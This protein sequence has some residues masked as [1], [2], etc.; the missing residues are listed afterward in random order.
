MIKLLRQHLKIFCCVILLIIGA[1]GLVEATRIRVGLLNVNGPFNPYRVSLIAEGQIIR[2][3]L[4]PLIEF[5]DS[6]LEPIL[7]TDLPSISADGLAYSFELKQGI[8]FHNQQELTTADVQLTIE[9]F[10]LDTTIINKD[11]WSRLKGADAFIEGVALSIA[12]IKII[13]DYRFKLT[14]AQPFPNFIQTLT[15]LN[16]VILPGGKLDNPLIGSGPFVLGSSSFTDSITL[17]RNENYHQQN[18]LISGLEFRFYTDSFAKIDAFDAGEIDVCPLSRTSYLEYAQGRIASEYIK[19]VHLNNIF[20]LMIGGEILK[21]SLLRQA[22]SLAINRTEIAQAMGKGVTP[23]HNF[24]PFGVDGAD[25]SG[26]INYS[27]EQAQEIL[28]QKGY[29]NGLE[30]TF[31]Q[32]QSFGYEDILTKMLQKSNIYLEFLQGPVEYF[33]QARAKGE[34]DLWGVGI[35]S[36]SA[37]AYHYF[38]PLILMSDW[39]YELNNALQKM[40][41]E[42][43]GEVNRNQRIALY[44]Q[45]HQLVI[46]EALVIPLIHQELLYLMNHQITDINY[47]G[48]YLDFKAASWY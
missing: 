25:I 9:N 7:L 5:R 40:L 16:A 24:L 36:S 45:L 13:D 20:F 46:D 27:S 32:G 26:R 44:Q 38:Q 3:V 28:I 29:S 10:L 48:L 2:Q 43:K 6:I 11:P 15:T 37:E 42:I 4:E 34:I 35:W 14:L 30:L 17:Q 1:G 18:A 31:W 19:G 39:G 23:A 22:L 33:V 12:G 8:F 41:I 47:S 21:D